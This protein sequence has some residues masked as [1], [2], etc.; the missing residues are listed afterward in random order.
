MSRYINQKG[1][2]ETV[3]VDK[4]GKNKNYTKWD[5]EYNGE[6]ANI[7]IDSN[8]NGKNSKYLI[9]LDNNDI[10]DLLSIQPI[11]RPLDQ[12]LRS[13][14]KSNRK[15]TPHFIEMKDNKLVS[16]KIDNKKLTHISSPI[17][18]EEFVIPNKKTKHTKRQ[19]RRNHNQN[20]KTF[21]IEKKYKSLPSRKHKKKIKY[22][23]LPSRKHKKIKKYTLSHS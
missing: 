23:S 4:N 15:C 7:I 3:I 16:S 10:A 11:N 13:D 17:Y 19:R 21:Y 20:H 22:K 9:K 18:S 12:R 5:A 14:F 2:A 8:T 1:I 6:N